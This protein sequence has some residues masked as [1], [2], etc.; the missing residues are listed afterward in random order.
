MIESND[1]DVL[2]YD[3]ECQITAMRVIKTRIGDLKLTFRLFFL[4]FYN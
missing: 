1:V 2:Q 3:I 4:T